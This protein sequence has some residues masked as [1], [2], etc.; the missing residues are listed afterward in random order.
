MSEVDFKVWHLK[1]KQWLDPLAIILTNGKVYR[2][3]RA[4]KDDL[5]FAEDDIKVLQWIGITDKNDKRVYDGDLYL[6]K[7]YWLRGDGYLKKAYPKEISIIFEVVRLGAGY[8]GRTHKAIP[9]HQEAFE[10][11]NYRGITTLED[12]WP[13]RSEQHNGIEVIGSIYSDSHLVEKPDGQCGKE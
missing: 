10:N 11:K 3:H 9:E 12:T 2:D 7:R 13:Y 1:E 5:A 6:G 4:Y 8:Q